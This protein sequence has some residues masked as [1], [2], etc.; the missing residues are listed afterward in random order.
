MNE[1]EVK[2]K[3]AEIHSKIEAIKIR[4][5]SLRAKLEIA[6]EA[7]I[8]SRD[9][10]CSEYCGTKGHHAYCVAATEALEAIRGAK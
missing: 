3:V 10:I 9:A 2:Q 8:G 7:L 6:I 5:D 1:F 4:V